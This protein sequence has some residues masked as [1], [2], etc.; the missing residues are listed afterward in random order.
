MKENLVFFYNGVSSNEMGLYNVSTKSGLYE[1]SFLAE[2]DIVEEKVR[3]NDKP[4]FMGIEREPISFTLAFAFMHPYD[5]Q[6]IREVARWLDQ[7]YYKELY[8][9]DKPNIRWLC[10]PSSDPKILHNG[11]GQGY[12]ELEF[13]CNSPYAHSEEYITEWYDFS[14]SNPSTGSGMN[15]TMNN[16][17]DISIYPEMW[18][19]KVGAGDVI[20]EN[21]ANGIKTIFT[22]LTDGELIYV[23]NERQDIESDLTQYTGEYRYD[24]FNDNYLEFEYGRNILN[25]KGECQIKF[26]FRYRFLSIQA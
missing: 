15:H 5:N 8:F 6:K 12:V 18:I 22:G 10:M 11:L 2:R 3:G 17:G 1:E 24:S 4:Y 13:R 19:K 16:L 7:D 26:R 23:D 14:V 21:N 20:V 9:E 25:I